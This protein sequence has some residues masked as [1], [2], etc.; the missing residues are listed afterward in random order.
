MIVAGG[1]VLV[2]GDVIGTGSSSMIVAGWDVLVSQ[3]ADTEILAGHN[4][5]VGQQLLNCNVTA[6]GRI[7]VGSSPMKSGIVSGGLAHAGRELALFRA[8]SAAALPPEL[9]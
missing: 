9:M 5:A 1:S 6:A 3:A 4:I 2:R 7:F 8:G